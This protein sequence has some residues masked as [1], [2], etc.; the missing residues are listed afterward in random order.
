MSVQSFLYIRLFNDAATSDTHIKYGQRIFRVH[1]PI[2]ACNSP[3]L[4]TYCASRREVI[5]EHATILIELQAHSCYSAAH[6]EAMLRFFYGNAYNVFEISPPDP[7]V[8]AS[9]AQQELSFHLRV[10]IAATVVN[11]PECLT[12]VSGKLES[13]LDEELFTAE[14]Y[15]LIVQ[16][17]MWVYGPLV[18]AVEEQ[19]KKK[20]REMAVEILVNKWLVRMVR[21]GLG[22]VL[23]KLMR[24]YP[25]LAIDVVICQNELGWD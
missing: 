14:S 25:D 13:M 15:P 19:V 16:F 1:E 18:T 8:N 3:A 7:S 4:E 24:K 2:L 23:K 12:Y 20:L 22:W 6:V 5:G 11:A 9:P 17:I 10:F 21:D